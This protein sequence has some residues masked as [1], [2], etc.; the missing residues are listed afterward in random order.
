MQYIVEDLA[1]ETSGTNVVSIKETVNGCFDPPILFVKNFQTIERIVF[2]DNY[3]RVT[4]MS[5]TTT[6]MMEI[7][8]MRFRNFLRSRSW[9]PI[10]RQ[11]LAL[12]MSCIFLNPRG[13]LT[14]QILCP[15]PYIAGGR[16]GQLPPARKTK[17]FFSNIVSDFA[18]LFLV[19]ILVRNLTKTE[20]A[21]ADKKS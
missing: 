9:L 4:W 14:R 21:P 20:Y 17:C 8:M 1:K 5:Q 12:K 10:E 19:A 15:G 16:R 11:Y 18:G 7:L 2:F 6:T 3:A 13:M